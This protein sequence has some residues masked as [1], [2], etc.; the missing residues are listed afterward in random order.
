MP[1]LRPNQ[2]A[3]H[4]L[5]RLVC[6]PSSNNHA[7]IVRCAG[8]PVKGSALLAVHTCIIA[9]SV[10]ARPWPIAASS[11]LKSPSMASRPP[12]WCTQGSGVSARF[13]PGLLESTG[14]VSQNALR[15]IL[16]PPD[17]RSP[18]LPPGCASVQ[19]G[20]CR[21]GGTFSNR[22]SPRNLAQAPMG[23]GGCAPLPC[24]IQAQRDQLDGDSCRSCSLRI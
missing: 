19:P 21:R 23:R 17:R 13:D 5:N 3:R 9:E 16:P 8:P 6:I 11:T 18:R 4:R 12:I 2:R 1:G 22:V 7:A 24:K 15:C 20:G 14:A 10:C